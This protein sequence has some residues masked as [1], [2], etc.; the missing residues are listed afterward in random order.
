MVPQ[1]D[2]KDIGRPSEDFMREV[3]KRGVAVV[4]GVVPT[5]EARGYKGEVEE[6]VKTNP[7]T[8]GNVSRFLEHLAKALW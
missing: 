8:K 6:Y 5:D 3:K 7:W 1:I 2:F 4:K